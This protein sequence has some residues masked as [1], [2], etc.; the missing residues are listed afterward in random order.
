MG[1]SACPGRNAVLQS[2]TYDQHGRAIH[3]PIFLLVGTQKTTTCDQGIRH[4]PRRLLG[5]NTS[6][7]GLPALSVYPQTSTGTAECGAPPAASWLGSSAGGRTGWGCL[8]PRTANPLPPRSNHHEHGYI[9]QPA[10]TDAM[11]LALA[12]RTASVAGS[13]TTLHVADAWAG[14]R[15]CA[16]A[17][18]ALG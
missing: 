12:A 3:A 7:C 10:P 8:R 4:E 16:P 9:F 5:R 6:A 14:R 18:R 15:C 2:E 13:M 11:Q 17:W 1:T